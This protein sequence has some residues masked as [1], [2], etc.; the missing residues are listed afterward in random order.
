LNIKKS[1]FPMVLVGIILISFTVTAFLL[2]EF[3]KTV[4]NYCALAFLLL[5][6]AV[7]FTGLVCLRFTGKNNNPVF[8][9]TGMSAALV[10]YFLA[11]LASVFI[12]GLLISNLNIF[13][14]IELAIIVLF[15][16]AAIAVYSF[17][18]SVRDNENE[19]IK[20]VQSHEAKR[21]GF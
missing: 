9:K 7:L 20:K 3:E 10:L 18:R 19:D 13:I 4:F 1:V 14:L 16:I 12:G 11:T 17:S 8:L 6:E 15:S 5:S 2:L 21:G